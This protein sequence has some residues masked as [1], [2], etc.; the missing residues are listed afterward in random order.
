MKKFNKT[1]VLAI[2]TTFVSSL[3][4]VSA[5]TDAFAMTELT[6][7]YMQLAQAD[8]TKTAP[9]DSKAKAPEAKCAGANPITGPKSAEAKCGAGKCGADMKKSTD[10]KGSDAKATE[11]KCGEGKCSSD[12]K[13]AAGAKPTETKP[14]Q[15]K[16]AVK[17]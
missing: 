10:T 6:Q 13:K 3:A 9:A 11:G 7:G 8:A 4:T 16:P 14:A 5:Q 15:E 2:G 17:K 1:L 12:M